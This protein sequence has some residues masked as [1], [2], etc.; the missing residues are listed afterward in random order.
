MAQRFPPRADDAALRCLQHFA[1]GL[2]ANPSLYMQSQA[3]V[4]TAQRVVRAFD[5]AFRVAS[6]KATR[7]STDVQAK[8][9]ARWAAEKFC[10]GVA[11]RIAWTMGISDADKRAIGVNPPNN[12]RTKIH[13]PQTCPVL[14]FVGGTPLS[15]TLRYADSTNPSR[16]AKPFGAIG[17]QLHHAIAEGPVRDVR[18]AMFSGIHA[19]NLFGVA[20]EPQ[21]RGK[22]ATYWGRWIGRGNQ[23]VG[24]WSLPLSMTIAA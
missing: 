19:R 14:T 5:E 24:P 21:Y 15:H 22:T 18:L 6:N 4:E 13:V 23:Q 3:E 9:Q 10:Q 12:T 17:L 1:D 7:S 8:D 11:R 20:F 2:A 16:A